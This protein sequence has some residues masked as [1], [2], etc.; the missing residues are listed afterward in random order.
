MD[1]ISIE[2]KLTREKFEE[3]IRSSQAN[4]I[5]DASREE[6]DGLYEAFVKLVKL[7]EEEKEPIN[8]SNEILDEDEEENE[9]LSICEQCGEKAWDGYICYS[10]GLKII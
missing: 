8:P 9:D 10:C 5:A 1:N 2:Q 7:L 4:H 6:L 3:I